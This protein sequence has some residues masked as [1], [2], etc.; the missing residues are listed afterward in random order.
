[1]KWICNTSK[2]IGCSKNSSNRG[3]VRNKYLYLKK[4]EKSNNL[5]LHSKEKKKR[6]E[7]K[8]RVIE[9]KVITKIRAEISNIETEKTIQKINDSSLRSLTNL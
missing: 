7:T 4:P 8:P 5:T 6:E 2:F 3:T 1:M 9:R